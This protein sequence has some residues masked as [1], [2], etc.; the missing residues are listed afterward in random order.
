MSFIGNQNIGVGKSNPNYHL[1]ISG[2]CFVSNNCYVNNN[3]GVGTN[4]PSYNLD[5][6]GNGRFNGALYSSGVSAML[7]QISNQEYHGNF[8]VNTAYQNTHSTPMFVTAV[9]VGSN[10]SYGVNS[11]SS[12]NPT[13]QI[14]NQTLAGGNG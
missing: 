5:V 11:D 2:N 4:N 7:K 10:T 1:D 9:V 3:L 14:F 12:T 8:T 13:T 6:S